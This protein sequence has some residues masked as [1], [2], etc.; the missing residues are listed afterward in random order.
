MP[1]PE[2]AFWLT[3][4]VMLVGL[5]GTLVPV[6]PGVELIWLAALVYAIAE[7]FATID[8]LTFAVLTALAAVGVLANFW[9]SQLGGRLG[10]ASWQAI[11]VGLVLGALG[12]IV[13][14][15]VGSIGAVPGGLIGSLAGILF[16]EY[17]RRKDWK[18]AIRAGTGWLAGCLLSGFIQMAAGIAMILIFVWQGL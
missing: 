10:G 5:I 1:L 15:L 9:A 16:V 8:P 4:G 6:L 13:G 3:L 12:F 7:R 17:H 18:R 2:W 11:L 14:A